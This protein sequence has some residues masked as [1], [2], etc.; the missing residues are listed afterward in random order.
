MSDADNESSLAGMRVMVVDDSR[1]I[2]RT[3]ET[4]LGKEGCDVCTASDGFEALAKVGE[5][6]PQLLFVD[7]MM[8]R[9]DGYQTCALIK[10]NPQFHDTPV[11]MLS[12]RDG[13]FDKARGRIVGAEQY[14]TKPFT[15][16]ELLAAVR[17]HARAVP[18]E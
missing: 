13:L 18:V 15:R 7:V 16:D 9:L 4:L 2:R 17:K 12:S 14:L 5:Q 11:I 8:P 6:K 3:A 1:T 10:G